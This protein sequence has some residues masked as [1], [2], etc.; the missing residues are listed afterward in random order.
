VSSRDAILGAM[1]RSM[2]R[3]PLEGEERAQAEARL[4]KPPVN[5]VPA[6]GQLPPSERVALFR[7]MATS[8][9]ATVERLDRADSIPDAVAAYLARE[10]LPSELRR[11][12]HPE[13]ERLDWS[14]KPLLS[15]S[16]GPA[17]GGTV[18][19]LS[20]AFA[21]IA[22]TGTL[23]LLS[24]PDGP[25]TLNFLPDHH[26]VLVRASA[27]VGAYED[28]W[29]KL[30]AVMGSRAM[31]RTVNLVTG[32]SRSADIEQTLQLGAHGPRR[33]H[34]LL[35]DDLADAGHRH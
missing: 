15:V 4:A 25:T 6:R 29:A 26:L 8:A 34:I 19:G 31:P 3:G 12:P 35:V 28:G 21:G 32:P 5:L 13:L 1:R 18:A 23:M 33:L 2:R 20:V 30:R 27:V 22:E 11:A 17:D 16:V 24:G 7:D 14:A 9:D 10:N